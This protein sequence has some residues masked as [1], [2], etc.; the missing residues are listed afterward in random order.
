MTYIEKFPQK[1]LSIMP[2]LKIRGIKPAILA[3]VTINTAVA[4]KSTLSG[5]DVA[6]PV[7]GR[8]RKVAAPTALKLP[9][10]QKRT[11]FISGLSE[12]ANIKQEAT[13]FPATPEIW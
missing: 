8:Q 11:S 13:T 4:L 5:P 7:L 1:K 12:N 10:T 2:L 3:S 9:S 6:A